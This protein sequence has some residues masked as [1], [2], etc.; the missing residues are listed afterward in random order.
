MNGQPQ[1]SVQLT[2]T[3]DPYLYQ[4]LSDLMG[5]EIVVQTTKNTLQGTLSGVTP[6]HIVININ[7]TP[8]FV[9]IQRIVW[10]SPS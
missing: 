8:F 1:Q 10:V 3:Y 7:R 5:N 4:T 6:D 9:R 2:S